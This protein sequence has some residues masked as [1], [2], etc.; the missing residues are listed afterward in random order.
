LFAGKPIADVESF[1]FV[2]N[3]NRFEVE[4]FLTKPIGMSV[5]SK[6]PLIVIIHGGPHG[7]DGPGFSFKNQVYAAH[8][9]AVLNV[10]YRGSLGYGQ[11]FSDAVFGDQDNNEGQDILYAV[12]AAVRRY[13]WID[14]ERLGIEGV[15]YGGQLAEWLIR[16]PMNS[17]RRFPR[18]VSRIWSATT[19]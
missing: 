19:T 7:Q 5:T 16:R 9:Y 1:T 14:R 4:A 8:G 18:Q 13:M 10:N 6:Y 3:D 17:R 15:S 11:K 2:S 12:S